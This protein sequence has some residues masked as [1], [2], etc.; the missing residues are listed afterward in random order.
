MFAA[1]TFWPR[2]SVIFFFFFGPSRAAEI[3]GSG[4]KQE[5]KTPGLTKGWL[6]VIGD[7]DR[8][9]AR[10]KF[11]QCRPS[12]TTITNCQAPSIGGREYEMLPWSQLSA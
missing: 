5:K 1:V 12:G 10:A 11:Q 8:R 3:S 6:R 4:E 2:D 7:A 9:L